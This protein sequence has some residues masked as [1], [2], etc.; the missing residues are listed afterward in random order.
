MKQTPH[1]SHKPLCHNIDPTVIYEGK[2]Q[3]R[4]LQYFPTL[5]ETDIS[6]G[7]PDALAYSLC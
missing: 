3:T 4:T 2:Q 7:F 5:N 1:S 6:F